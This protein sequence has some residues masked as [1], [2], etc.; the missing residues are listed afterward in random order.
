M[1]VHGV[2]VHGL[3]RKL[4]VEEWS[5]A[6]VRGPVVNIKVG[7]EDEPPYISGS[8]IVHTCNRIV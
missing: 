1:H 2:G 5:D 8:Q 3:R 7:P 6:T 4:L